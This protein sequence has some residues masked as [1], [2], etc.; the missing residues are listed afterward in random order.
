MRDRVLPDDIDGI[1]VAEDLE[2]A[3]I[4]SYPLVLKIL[5]R[6]HTGIEVDAAGCFIGPVAGVAFNGNFHIPI[7]IVLRFL[8]ISP[9]RHPGETGPKTGFTG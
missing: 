3:V 5:D 2:I 8:V 7:V 1:V 4:L 9:P 6:H